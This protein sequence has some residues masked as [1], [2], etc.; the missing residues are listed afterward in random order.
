MND[1]ETVIVILGAALVGFVAG[2][3]VILA[4]LNRPTD[5]QHLRGWRE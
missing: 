4:L 5:R 2:C 3:C 1:A